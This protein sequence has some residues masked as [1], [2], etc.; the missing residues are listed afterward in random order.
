MAN[1]PSYYGFR[2]IGRLDGAAPNYAP[3]TYKIKSDNTSKIHFGSPVVSLSTGYITVAAPGTTQLAG[4][5]IGCK[6]LNGEGRV[7]RANKWLGAASGAAADV[8]AFV[9]DDPLAIFQARSGT[10]APVAF[11]NIGENINFVIDPGD[12]RS[13]ISRAYVNQ[14]TLAVTTTLPFR[15][16]D[17]VTYPP[18]ADGADATSPFNDVI[19]AWNHQNFKVLTGI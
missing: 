11:A 1:T 6:F 2:H 18:G 14:A 9:I 5:F 8:D 3:R 16:I 17:I 10:A 19:L 12:D 15:V 4:V 13:G 7:R